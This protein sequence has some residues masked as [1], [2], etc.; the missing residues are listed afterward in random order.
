MLSSASHLQ[1]KDRVPQM[2]GREA[3]KFVKPSVTST[4][5]ED[6]TYPPCAALVWAACL[7]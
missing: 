1:Q 5:T 7:C 3:I 2:L 4:V 6:T